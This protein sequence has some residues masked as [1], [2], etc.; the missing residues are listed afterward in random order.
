MDQAIHH[1]LYPNVFLV[2]KLV[3]VLGLARSLAVRPY[4]SYGHSGSE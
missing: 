2:S 4:L 3:R 1:T